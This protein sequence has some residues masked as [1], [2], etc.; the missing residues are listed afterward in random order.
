MGAIAGRSRAYAAEG[1]AAS[2]PLLDRLL[3]IIG[4]RIERG[5]LPGLKDA[6]VRLRD[7]AG[8]FRSAPDSV[9]H[10]D[11]HPQN[12][13]V[14]GMHVTGVIDWVNADCG[15]RHLDAA[16]TSVILATSAMEH[17]RWMREN[18][19]G[20]VLRAT[21]AAMYLPLYHASMPM[22]L[23]RFRYCQG[24]AAMMRLSM[25]GMMRQRGPEAV[26]FRPEAIA[27]VTPPVVRLLSRYASRKTGAPV[28]I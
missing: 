24:V 7:R 16:T 17:P 18:P 20:N 19:I 28:A 12:V 2:A 26:G 13:L 9:V 11:Y 23:Q 27:N 22:E 15:D 3:G 14:R 6:F 10:M 5:P 1:I 25:F 21:F 8:R 4:E